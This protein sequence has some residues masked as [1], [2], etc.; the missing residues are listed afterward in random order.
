MPL[1]GKAKLNELLDGPL[2]NIM[3][4]FVDDFMKENAEVRHTAGLKAKVIRTMN[5][6]CCPWCAEVAG[7]YEYPNVPKDVY[8]RHDNCDCTVVY[9]S[10]K[11]RQDV[12]SK[13]WLGEERDKRIS[14]T[15]KSLMSTKEPTK[16]NDN[17]DEKT[18]ELTKIL[19]RLKVEYN[20]VTMRTRVASEE[21]IIK[22]IAG[23]DLTKGSCASLGF[24]YAGQKGGMNVLDFRGGESQNFFSKSSNILNLLKASKADILEEG[25]RS[26]ITAGKKLLKRV[27]EGKE[28]YFCCGKHAAIVRSN[29]GVLQYLELQ[30]ETDSGWTNFNGNPGY[31]LKKRFG[32]TKPWPGSTRDV[33]AYMA[34]IDTFKDSVDLREAL[35]YINTFENEQTKGAKG[36]AK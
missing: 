17:L 21:E 23:G 27:E 6:P 16:G 10:E 36:Y 15:N 29:G 4:S 1:E 33:K 25:A 8:R 30:S 9:V 34:D 14:E 24:V 7:T 32:E 35:G 22:A 13:K 19:E 12:W 31:T 20:P 28:Y 3:M 11:G 18:R 5:K 26:S 2:R